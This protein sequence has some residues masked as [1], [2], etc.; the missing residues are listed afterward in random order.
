MRLIDEMRATFVVDDLGGCRANPVAGSLLEALI[1]RRI[2]Q[3]KVT[4]ITIWWSMAETFSGVAKEQD[5][6]A[7][8]RRI[9]EKGTVYVL[10]MYCQE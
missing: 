1:K 6:N 9:S 2:D 10:Q 3:A 8:S 7:I 4:I 5:L